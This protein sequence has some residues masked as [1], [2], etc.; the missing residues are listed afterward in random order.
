MTGK[1]ITIEGLEGAGKTTQAQVLV[2]WL[3]S[4]GHKIV[5]TR[6]PGGTPV[7][8]KIRNLI[9]DHHEEE[10]DPVAE[11]LL[12]FASRKQHVERLIRP[13]IAAGD[14]VVSDR[15]TDAT[16]AYQGGG[17]CLDE[18]LIREM[19]LTVL[20]DFQPDLTIWFDCDA[21]VGLARASARGELDRI[22]QESMAFFNRCR[23]AYE[24]RAQAHPQRFIRI[25][26]NNPVEKVTEELLTA[27]EAYFA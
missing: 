22:E 21:E 25:N 2:E 24:R 18:A 14:W 11:L 17:R 13:G 16:Y 5:R 12:V 26:A 20:D 4:R 23:S 10:I 8:E 19:E 1:F 7:A 9:L 15:F 6:E 3:A 27:L